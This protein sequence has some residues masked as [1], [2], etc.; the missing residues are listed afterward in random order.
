MEE[1]SILR[2]DGLLSIA[3]SFQTENSAALPEDTLLNSEDEIPSA[4]IQRSTY[5]PKE[6][7]DEQPPKPPRS[8][9][10]RRRDTPRGSY[11]DPPKKRPRRFQQEN[12]ENVKEKIRKSEESIS[13]L[14]AHSDKGTCPKTLRYNARANISPDEEFKQDI[15]LIRKNAQQ[16]YLGALI[17]FHYRRVE[18]NKIKLNRI[19]QLEQRKSN[20]ENLAKNKAHP[21]VREPRANVNKHEERI[22]NIQKRMD[23][24]KQMML[25]I[26]KEQNKVPESYPNA[27]LLSTN[28]SKRERVPKHVIHTK[29]RNERRKKLKRD[30]DQK[31]LE[32]KKRYIKNL[33]DSELTRD[34]INLLSR[35]LK[36][37]PTPVTSVSHI[38]Q[39]L[40][41]DSKRS[42][43]E[44]DYSI[45]FMVRTKSHTP[46][47]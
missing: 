26:H 6:R 2:E 33:S 28:H 43:D 21:T 10:K 25:N 41:N 31:T 47:T 9:N 32:S 36:F 3:A 20:D 16:K 12:A 22:E 44:C 38:R 18:R 35:G 5:K 23:E 42:L 15:A 39:Q 11:E 19:Q 4:Q 27:S 14:K 37:I 24:L 40:L 17:K 7:Q 30:I 34:Q 13:K 46:S 29:K 8:P 1:E 45:C